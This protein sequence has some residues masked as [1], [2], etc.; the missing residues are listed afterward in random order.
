MQRRTRSERR[1]SSHSVKTRSAE[2]RCTS[3]RRS[4]LSRT[5]HCAMMP[6]VRLGVAHVRYLPDAA[7]LGDA[8]QRIEW[9][10][11]PQKVPLVPDRRRQK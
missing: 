2:L 5:S 6:D 11:G 3:R 4:L 9:F 10:N 1:S 8:N 7:P